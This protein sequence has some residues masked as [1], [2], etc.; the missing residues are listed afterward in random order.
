MKYRPIKVATSLRGVMSKVSFSIIYMTK[1]CR[2][3]WVFMILQA[4]PSKAC[5]ISVGPLKMLMESQP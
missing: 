5:T 1:I 4:H 3:K 2:I